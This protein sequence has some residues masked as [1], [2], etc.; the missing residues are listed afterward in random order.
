MIQILSFFVI[1]VGISSIFRLTWWL[2]GL[3]GKLVGASNAA[4]I[5]I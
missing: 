2:G 3:E 5:I 4:Q 1:I